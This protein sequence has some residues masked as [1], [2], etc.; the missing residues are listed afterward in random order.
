MDHRMVLI[1]YREYFE[2]RLRQLLEELRVD[3]F[4]ETPG[5][6]GGGD[7]GRAED[8]S[9]WP[10]HNSAIFTVQEPERALELVAA[11]RQL[12]AEET[13]RRHGEAVAI[14]AFVFPCEIAV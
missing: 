8:S 1:V 5:M 11:V 3:H 13:E 2:E 7:A 9:V 4:S 6:L 10:G 14:R 12:V